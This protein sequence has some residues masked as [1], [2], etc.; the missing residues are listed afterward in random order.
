M[1]GLPNQRVASTPLA[2][3]RARHV[4]VEGN[5]EVAEAFQGLMG[6]VMTESFSAR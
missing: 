6:Q 2:E 5:P 4:R 3:F 1:T